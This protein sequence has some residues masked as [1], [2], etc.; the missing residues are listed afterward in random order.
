M[1]VRVRIAATTAVA[2]QTTRHQSAS[3][4]MSVV[5]RR[6]AAGQLNTVWVC[7]CCRFAGVTPANSIRP[8][9]EMSG[10]ASA[11][12]G[13]LTPHGGVTNSD[14]SGGVQKKVGVLTP[15]GIPDYV[16]QRDDVQN[17][18]AIDSAITDLCMREKTRVVCIFY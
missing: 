9:H 1:G 11:S 17:L 7:C 15:L 13:D 10:A 5:T 4:G 12:V 16:P 8:I 2:S 14:W 3:Y 6:L 18:V